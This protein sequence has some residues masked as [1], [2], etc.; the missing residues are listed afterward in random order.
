M[1]LLA[2]T[3]LQKQL[4]KFWAAPDGLSKTKYAKK[5]AK[6]KPHFDTLYTALKTGGTY[7][8]VVQTGFFEW[9]YKRKQR[10]NHCL[11][12]VP[13]NYSPHQKYELR[14]VLHGG[15]STIDPKAAKRWV[16]QNHPAYKNRQFITVY[17]SAWLLNPWLSRLRYDNLLYLLHRLKQTYNIDENR[18][19]L[20]GISDGGT[21]VY[22]LANC[23]THQWATM[24]PF[25]STLDN[26]SGLTDM[27]NANIRPVFVNNYINVPFLAINTEK[28]KIFP[29]K[30][31]LPYFNL[32]KQVGVDLQVHTVP[33]TAHNMD[34]YPQ[35][36][37]TINQFIQTHQRKPYPQKALWQTENPGQ[38]GRCHWVIINQ[39]GNGSDFN[40]LPD[41]NLLPESKT[42]ALPRHMPS[43][44]IE[45]VRT[46]N[47]IEVTTANVKRYTL[48]LSPDVFD[49]EQ[50]IKVF[51]NGEP[52]FE[53]KLEPKTETLLK[54][55]AIDNDRT[56]LYGAEL[57]IIVK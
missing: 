50:T 22:Y 55:A 10:D 1:R 38:F 6:L 4:A 45:A 25:I 34:W 41:N 27:P 42:A 23:S 32:M 36:I 43:G 11:I 48:L 53:G 54:Y 16:D 30:N 35:Y 3:D 28:D 13:H 21:G 17:P 47:V 2:Q 33:N 40:R 9:N 7:S 46:G 24:Q 44:I 18:V 8:K 29:L 26:L 14:F 49:F 5:I 52:S 57:K 51:T 39:L 31:A 20:Q 12:F 15:V 37:D 19:H 56:S